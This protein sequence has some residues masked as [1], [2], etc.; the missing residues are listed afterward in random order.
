M[1]TVLILLILIC[2][3]ILSFVTSIELR[4]SGVLYDPSL[5]TQNYADY[6]AKRDAKLGW[7]RPTTRT[8]PDFPIAMQPCVS[9]FGDSFTWGSEV[10]D[11]DAWGA[12]LA[13]KLKCRVA[14]YGVG[15]YGSDQAYLLFRS[16]PPKGEVVFLNHLSENILRNVNQYRNLLYPGREFAFK[17]RFLTH[18]GA[19]ELVPIPEIAP[20]EIASFLAKPARYLMHEYFL[21]GTRA[22]IEA[23]GFPY[24]IAVFKAALWNYHVRAKLANTPRHADFY[25]PD[26][27]SN[28]LA[29][30]FAILHSFV[31]TATARGQIPVVTLIPVCDDLKYFKQRGVFPYDALKKMIVAENLRYIDFGDEIA[32]RIAASPPENL[33]GNCSDHFNAAGYRLMA[34]IAFD[35]LQSNPE[36]RQRLAAGH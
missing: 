22:G 30:T 9:L 2:V 13:R 33:Y 27:A 19:I 5:V 14:N 32:K 1:Y 11:R 8:D 18:N 21:P 4:R 7:R 10:A 15:G 28:G 29:V 12:I 6:L 16:L 25:R 35:Y 34:E 31:E 24:S 36:I 26:H 3:E 23:I 17:P 20:S